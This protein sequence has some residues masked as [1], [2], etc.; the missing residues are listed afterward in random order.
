MK[1]INNNKKINVKVGDVIKYWD[2]MDPYPR[3][4][5][6]I[7]FCENGYSAVVLSDQNSPKSVGKVLLDGIDIT[8]PT[9]GTDN[10]AFTY[11]I[12]NTVFQ[13]YWE[14]WDNVEKVPFF[15]VEGHPEDYKAG[16]EP[17]KLVCERK[18]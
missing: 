14:S 13:E 16:D 9:Y 11:G 5:M 4:A 7:E 18:L 3:Y 15:G 1:V 12:P 8:N 2:K 17:S 6:I 10:P